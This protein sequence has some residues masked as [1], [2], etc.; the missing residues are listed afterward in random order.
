MKKEKIP[1]RAR[2]VVEPKHVDIELPDAEKKSLK[3]MRKKNFKNKAD[4]E[5]WPV[6]VDLKRRYFFFDNESDFDGNIAVTILHWSGDQFAVDGL[7]LNMKVSELKDR[8]S[9]LKGIEKKKQKLRLNGRIVDAK[10]TLLKAGIT[11]NARLTLD[12]PHKNV[13]A[14]PD[15]DKLS[16][17]KTSLGA[18]KLV[19]QI[20][21][22]VKTWKEEA[23]ELK[24]LATA[25]IDDI[26]DEVADLHNVTL[27]ANR[28]LFQGKATSET[29]TLAEQGIVDGSTLEFVKMSIFVEVPTKK[30]PVT[31]FVEH[32]HTIGKIKRNL[33]KKIKKFPVEK[34]CIMFGGEELSNTKTMLDY[35]IDHGDTLTLE[36][37]RV[38][39]IQLS[40]EEFDPEGISR[41]S[42]INDVKAKIA[43]EFGI[44]PA[45]QK[46]LLKGAVLNDV[47]RLCDQGVEH[48]AILFLEENVATNESDR[49]MKD[50]VGFSFLNLAKAIGSGSESV[51]M[52]LHIKHWNGDMFIVKVQT[53]DY[54]DDVREKIRAKKKIPVEKQRLKCHGQ[55]VDDAASLAEQGICDGT[56]I[57]LGRLEI[58]LELPNGKI[59][60][61]ETTPDESILRLKRQIKEKTD[62]AIEHQNLMFGSEL[63]ENAKKISAYNL[64]HGDTI[65][66]EHFS[67]RVADW[68]GDLF[69]VDGIESSSNV[70][71]LQKRI[72]EIKGISAN[73]LILK[74]NSKPLNEMLKLSHQG[75]THRSVLVLEPPDASFMSPVHAKVKIGSIAGNDD[76]SNMDDFDTSRSTLASLSSPVITPKKNK[77]KTKKKKKVEKAKSPESAT[78]ST[79]K[80]KREVDKKSSR[81]L[82]SVKKILTR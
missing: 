56:T 19:S 9:E 18:K 43:R 13:I 57:E 41:M 54:P 16:L 11:H 60:T 45:C 34:Q 59:V 15:L 71:E 46:L 4:E 48:G 61:V 69:E 49:N 30:K 70:A 36:L 14:N 20:S 25:Y 73:K 78:T 8:I 67:V 37:F 2:I 81:L 17:L 44:E 31:I 47:L 10:K 22:T 28:L 33:A 12:S 26:I 51:E 53:D 35:S 82:K 58:S 68:H 23:F 42:T 77:K 40:G 6:D 1:H 64:E 32:D 75:V 39:I 66:L 74:L 3:K 21:I 55:N 76:S 52:C 27:E 65:K 62:E 50:K 80:E 63:L 72:E 29:M 7:T 5:I 38:R 79:P 24:P